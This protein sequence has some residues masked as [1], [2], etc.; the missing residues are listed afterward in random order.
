ML[1]AGGFSL[2][3]EP[4]HRHLL[5][6]AELVQTAVR[7]TGSP[8]YALRRAERG[9]AHVVARRASGGEVL[10]GLQPHEPIGVEPRSWRPDLLHA[11]VP[12]A[13]GEPRGSRD[14]R[15]AGVPFG[16]FKGRTAGADGIAFDSVSKGARNSPG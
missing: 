9:G 4:S 5:R 15:A 11:G 3:V 6:A 8:R 7:G 10:A 12:G 14:Q 2:H 16:A 1:F 13:P